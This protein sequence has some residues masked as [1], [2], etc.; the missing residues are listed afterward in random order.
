MPYSLEEISQLS[1]D[2]KPISEKKSDD[3]GYFES[4]L[5]GVATG[6]INVPKGF[7]SLG[8]QLYDLIGDTNVSKEIDDYVDKMNPFHD[9]AEANLAGKIT[10]T[11]VEFA[12]V[13]W[14]A[15]IGKGVLNSEQLIAN[16]A[17]DAVEAKQAGKYFNL[18]RIGE[19]IVGPKTGAI[20][21][22]G[23]G[24]MFVS[25]D[26]IGTL[27]DML[28]GTA[29]E[30]Y[31]I[32]VTDQETKEGRQEAARRLL[33]RLKF[34]TEVSLLDLG[35]TGIGAGIGKLR[36]PAEN[37][38]ITK[39][40]DT[41][42]IEMLQ[43]GFYGLKPSGFGTVKTFEAQ[44]GMFG[45][46]EAENL[47]ATLQAQKLQSAAE[48]TWEKIKDVFLN[49]KDGVLTE[50][51]GKKLFMR[52]ITE[53]SSPTERGA[54]SLL[55]PEAKDRILLSEIEPIKKVKQ[56]YRYNNLDISE[57]DFEKLSKTEKNIATPIEPEKYLKF[58]YSPIKGN[59]KEGFF[60]ESDYAY[61]NLM[62]KLKNQIESAGGDAQPLLDSIINFRLNVDNMSVDILQN[63]LPADIANGIKNKLGTYFTGSYKSFV[64]ET[65][66][67]SIVQKQ[68]ID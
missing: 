42:F 13:G 30:P 60:S 11:L 57:E 33:N 66:D 62:I 1:K 35:L 53:A 25:D 41:P 45:N 24:G 64:E 32:T 63:R 59:K 48:Q 10:K 26:D 52:N 34:G 46:I 28:K 9:A 12:P 56:K 19:K 2:I 55:K 67:I 50:D 16:M 23:V 14:G 27:G 15:K 6:I 29:L 20:L 58:E 39:F 3:I 7:V 51:Q 5:A 54:S 40:S 22:A 4:A 49:T 8:A 65:E 17:K 61:N 18:S 21:G 37:A 43:R 36:A 44:K 47:Q 68:L 38:P 31:W